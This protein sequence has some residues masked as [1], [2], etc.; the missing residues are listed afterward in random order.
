MAKVNRGGK[1]LSGGKYHK[2]D[3]DLKY[4]DEY[5]TEVEFKDLNVKVII[6]KLEDTARFPQDSATPNRIYAIPLDNDPNKPLKSFAFYDEQ[7]RK[8]KQIDRQDHIIDE[9]RVNPHTHY[10]Y[11]HNE[12]G[13]D[14]V[15]KD[16]LKLIEK[17][18]KRWYNYL[19]NK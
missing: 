3:K 6:N 16:D 14:F 12:G 5:R 9:E 7:G 15:S 17:I 13:D 1:R 19:N 2:Y 4:G 10:G 18:E 11:Y 8:Y